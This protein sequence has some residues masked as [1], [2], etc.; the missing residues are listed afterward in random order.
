MRDSPD[1]PRCAGG[2]SAFNGFDQYVRTRM[3][4]YASY[5]VFALMWSPRECRVTALH[6]ILPS[7]AAAGGR[8][9]FGQLD[10]HFLTVYTYADRSSLQSPGR[11]SGSSSDSALEG[12]GFEPLVPREGDW[13]FRDHLDRPP[14]PSPP[15]EA[16]YLARETWSLPLVCSAKEPNSIS[17]SA[18]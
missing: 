5:T 11:H 15:R 3:R 14:A 16:P 18:R 7:S 4:K 17:A 9:W 6:L 12:D 13:P 1:I 10:Y 2:F 8:F